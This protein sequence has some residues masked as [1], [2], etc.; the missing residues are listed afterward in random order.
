MARWNDDRPFA[1]ERPPP[2]T[3]TFE[4]NS[5]LRRS[6]PREALALYAQWMTRLPLGR[7]RG[8]AKPN[9]FT[10][11]FLL[12]ASRCVPRAVPL[13]HAHLTKLSLL[14]PDPFLRSS[15]ISAYAYARPSPSS[16][17]LLRLFA[18]PPHAA[19]DPVLRTSLLSALARC[20]RPDDAR[21]AFDDM[22]R[23]TPVSW[24]ALVSAYARAGRPA[25]ALAALRRA[26]RAG[27]PPTEAALVSSL[28]AA[29]ALGA[30]AE[31]ERAHRDAVARGHPLSPALGTAL[32]DMYA[33]CGRV[34]AARRVFDEMPA[35]DGAAWTAMV[36]A[37]AAH[38]RGAEALGLFEEMVRRGVRPDRVAYVGALH[39]CS[40]AGLVGEARA[41]LERMRA[42]HGIEPGPEH[43]GC[44]VDA[45]G[46]AGRV[47]AAW[48]LVRAMPVEP[49]ERVLKALL[50]AS[51]DRGFAPC[52]EWAAE[53]LTRAG[54]ASVASAYV[55]LGNMYAA[56][57]RWDESARARK[58]MRFCGVPKSPGWSSID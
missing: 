57:G 42:A 53:R 55:M 28:S 58:M 31:G 43:Y 10:F 50:S 5:I 17:L 51:C 1:P 47:E 2:P 30:L 19:H 27:A 32:L 52:A 56:M 23:P 21:R 15:L 11:T 16:S 48:E 38:G 36:A 22:P 18:L 26:R 20:G 14:L 45:L 33:K 8:G 40:H 39:A 35:R 54:T 37:L 12:R 24:A 44:V 46:R 49:D 4:W 25:D 3:T 13:L 9:K 7:G 34:G 6:P 41:L 29:A